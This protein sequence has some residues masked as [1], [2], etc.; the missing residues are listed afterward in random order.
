[1]QQSVPLTKLTRSSALIYDD[2]DIKKKTETNWSQSILCRWN[3]DDLSEFAEIDQMKQ[4]KPNEYNN[5]CGFLFDF[6]M[7]NK[8]LLT[9]WKK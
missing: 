5:C 2:C 3:H 7:S 1:M 6:M 8:I 4:I 9:I